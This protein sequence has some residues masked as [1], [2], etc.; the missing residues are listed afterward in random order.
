ETYRW[1]SHVDSPDDRRPAR[2]VY[3][4]QDHVGSAGD[5]PLDRRPHRTGR[6]GDD[7]HPAELGP[8]TGPVR[9]VVVHQE[10]PDG[11]LAAHVAGQTIRMFAIIAMSSCS[12]LWQWKT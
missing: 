11:Y 2:R 1:V 12:R 4:Q 3:I 10:Y 8:E 9:V 6:S 5:D 7:E